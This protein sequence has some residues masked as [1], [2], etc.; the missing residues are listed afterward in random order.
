MQ[1]ERKNKNRSILSLLS[2]MKCSDNL[3]KY[4]FQ[5]SPKGIVT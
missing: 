2:H 3:Y 1:M 4:W 5:A